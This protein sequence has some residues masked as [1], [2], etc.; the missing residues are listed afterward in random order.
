MA[1]RRRV[2]DLGGGIAKGEVGEST[3]AYQDYFKEENSANRN[4]NYT[5]VVNK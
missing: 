1:A 4:A 5:D 3:E 2:A